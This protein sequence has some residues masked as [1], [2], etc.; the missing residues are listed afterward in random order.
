MTKPRPGIDSE[1]SHKLAG[2]PLISEVTAELLAQMRQYSFPVEHYLAGRDVDYVDLTIPATDNYELPVTVL[3]P[4]KA[5]AEPAPCIYWVHGGGMITGNRFSNLDIPLAWLE[6]LGAVIVTIDYRLAPEATGSTLVGDCY[7]GLVWLTENAAELGIDPTRIIVAGA[8][9]GGGLAAG[10]TLMARDRKGPSIA[11][12]VLICPMLDHRNNSVS[13]HQYSAEPGLWTRESNQFG[14]G[15]VLANTPRDEVSAYVSA[16]MAQDLA[17]LPTTYIDVGSAE[18]FRDECVNYASRIWAAG[19]QA[20]LHVWA[21]GVHG[22]DAL[23][24]D[25]SISISARTTRT[26]WLSRI[27]KDIK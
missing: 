2:M 7:Q 27:L 1:L 17:N 8:S 4:A 18:V 12:Q 21:G 10:T 19:G 23:F 22:F 15:S 14:W 5:A 20:E 3:R 26:Q 25:A 24:P 9:A 11:A 13:S 6:S 16:A